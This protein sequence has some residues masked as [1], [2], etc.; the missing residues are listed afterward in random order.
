MTRS[1]QKE[2]N[3]P[4]RR[5]LER[6]A[7][8]RS[9]ER[10]EGEEEPKKKKAAGNKNKRNKTTGRN[11]LPTREP[12]EGEEDEDWD[13]RGD[14]EDYV[15]LASVKRLSMRN[16]RRMDDT[17]K[18]E[19]GQGMFTE[20][21]YKNKFW[22][23]VEKFKKEM[24]TKI[25]AEERFRFDNISIDAALA[26]LS[27]KAYLPK[28]RQASNRRYPQA[29]KMFFYSSRERRGRAACGLDSK[30]TKN[31]FARHTSVRSNDNHHSPS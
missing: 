12:V 5:S 26:V 21:S 14:K 9:V 28:P 3:S 25:S 27:L 31:S 7:K 4:T 20:K 16:M 13:P 11:Q 2:Q 8:K 15:Y 29:G 30:N 18:L 10:E 23:R 19:G 24:G 22:E 1:E 6:G 17:L